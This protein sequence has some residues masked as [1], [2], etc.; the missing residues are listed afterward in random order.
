MARTIAKFHPLAAEFPSTNFPQLLPVHTTERRPVLAYDGTTAEK[1]YWSTKAPQQ[2]TTPLTMVLT[3]IAAS[4]T[5]GAVV[6]QCQVEAIT[7]GDAVDT[8]SAASFGTAN[9]SSAVTVAGT[10]GFEFEIVITL[11]NNDAIAAGDKVRFSVE[12][13]PANAGDTVTTD[14]YLVM[15]EVRDNG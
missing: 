15:A 11:T 1:A 8:D 10:A 12:R 3:L 5:T 13:L 14:V 7:P 4:A 2:L 9:I 6:Y